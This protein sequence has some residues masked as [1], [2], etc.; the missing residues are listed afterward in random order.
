MPLPIPI[1]PLWPD[2]DDTSLP[3]VSPLPLVDPDAA[4]FQRLM[5]AMFRRPQ[6]KIVTDYFTYIPSVNAWCY[7]SRNFIYDFASVP[8]PLTFMFEPTG[9]WAYPAG[10][11]DF[12][13]R[14]AGLMLSPAPG[15]AYQFVRQSRSD[16]DHIFRSL[17][18]KAN[19]LSTINAVGT[20]ALSVAGGLNYNPINIEDIDWTR[21]VTRRYTPKALPS[22][23]SDSLSR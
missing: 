17:S 18:D 15:I 7:L 9:L 5:Q 4:W 14:F 11:H 3:I 16:L 12:G 1:N 10:P 13:Y 19:G 8:R 2:K 23:R 21:P 20:F 6:Y 22:V